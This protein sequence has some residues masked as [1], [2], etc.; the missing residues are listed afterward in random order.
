MTP[1]GKLA[2]VEELK[3]EGKVVAMVGDGVN[4]APALAY[5]DVGIAVARGEDVAVEAAEVVLMKNAMGEC[6]GPK[7][8]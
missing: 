1:A 3:G 4:D 6:C 7:N 5:A 2:K 8:H